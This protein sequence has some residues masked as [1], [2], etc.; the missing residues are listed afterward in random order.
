MNAWQAIPDID[1]IVFAL[2]ECFTL[3]GVQKQK[4]ADGGR[5][6]AE[7]YALPRVLKEHMLPALRTAGERFANQEPVTIKPRE[8]K[9]AA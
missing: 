8:L 7:G 2:E 3:S 9:A 6:H 4:M 5:R 1:D